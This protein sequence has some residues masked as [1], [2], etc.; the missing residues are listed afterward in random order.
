VAVVIPTLNESAVIAGCLDALAAQ[1]P[2]EVVVV[3]AGSGDGTA[4]IAAATGLARVISTR[5]N[6]GAQQNAGARATT[7]EVMLFLHADCRLGVGA[8]DQVRAIARRAPRCPGGCLRMR[9]EDADWRFRAIDL[10]ADV[11]AGVLGLPYGDQ[12]IWARRAAFERVGGFPELR[13][14]DDLGFAM[15]LR[16]LGRLVV[17]PADVS[18]SPRRWKSRGLLRQTLTNWRLTLLATLGVSP[19][20]LARSYG[21]VR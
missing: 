5:R 9:V 14:M 2:D 3:D 6:R 18:V 4:M 13:L 19:N 7:A 20:R 10:A 17:A 15:R 21:S 11:R 16:R 1:G 12:A 8:L